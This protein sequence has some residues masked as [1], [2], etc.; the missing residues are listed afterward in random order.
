MHARMHGRTWLLPTFLFSGSR[1]TGSR[2][3]CPRN[4][5]NYLQRLP[6]YKLIPMDQQRMN[7]LRSIWNLTNHLFRMYLGKFR[8]VIPCGTRC[9]RCNMRSSSRNPVNSRRCHLTPF[10]RMSRS[11]LHFLQ[12]N[13]VEEVHR[14]TCCHIPLL[15]RETINYIKISCS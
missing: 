3:I 8:L 15:Q 14:R 6:F 11:W 7:I 2:I 5:W 10:L 4:R 9:R 12:L 13:H 1:Q